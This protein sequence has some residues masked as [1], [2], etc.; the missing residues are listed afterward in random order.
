M[1]TPGGWVAIIV[2]PAV[3][4]CVCPDTNLISVGLNCQRKTKERPSG[5]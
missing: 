3:N 4:S 1:H 2:H 5:I